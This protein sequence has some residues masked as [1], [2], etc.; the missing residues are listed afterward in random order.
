MNV[1]ME[2]QPY[3]DECVYGDPIFKQYTLLSGSI[4]IDLLKRNIKASKHAQHLHM[5][6]NQWPHIH[7]NVSI[8]CPDNNSKPLLVKLKQ[9]SSCM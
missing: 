9:T 6:S 8:T 3:N 1:F 2:I 4:L 5:S 7:A